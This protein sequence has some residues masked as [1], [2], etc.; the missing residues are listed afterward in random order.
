MSEF[1]FNLNGLNISEAGG[2]PKIP[3]GLSSLG[4][5]LYSS[6]KDSDLT[7]TGSDYI[8]W[9]RTNSERLR[10]GLPSLADIGYPRPPEDATLSTSTSAAA[11]AAGAETFKIK[12]PPGMTLEQA[13]AIFEQQVKTGGV[14]GFAP[15]DT[16]SAATQAFD[17]L[18]AAKAQFGQS[19]SGLNGNLPIGTNLQT[20]SKSLGPGGV[21][22]ANQIGAFATGAAAAI[23]S[24]RVNATGF[25]S[26]S[27]AQAGLSQ[28]IGMLPQVPGEINAALTRD[29]AAIAGDLKSFAGE[30]NGVVG[31][32]VST[33]SNVLKGT[34][35][36]GIGVADLSKAVTAL[37][38]LPGLDQNQV[39]AS[40]AQAQKLAS[41]KFDQ[42][43]NGTGVGAF[44]FDASQLEKA[45]LVK[46]GT[47]AEFLAQGKN[48]L[49]DVLKSPT[50]WTGKEGVKKVQDFLGNPALQ[51][52]IQQGLMK[53][54]L[55]ELKQLGVPTDKMTPQALS[56]LATN[57]AKSVQDTFKW[58]QNSPDLP[59]S[60]KEKFDKTA[61]NSAFAINLVENKVE[62]P[63]LKEKVIE[64]SENTVNSATVDAAASRVV[65]ND[66]VPDV[67]AGT[68]K[69]SAY[70]TVLTFQNFIKERIAQFKALKQKIEY[71]SSQY[72][73][74]TQEQWNVINS[75][76]VAIRATVRARAGELL[77]AA[78]A[79]T[80]S[81]PASGQTYSDKNTLRQLN[82]TIDELV[83][84]MDALNDEI[85]QLVKNLAGKIYAQA[86]RV[87]NQ[88][89]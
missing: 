21:D 45:G 14:T 18:E 28:A 2:F 7:Y 43:T 57:A 66:K 34:P 54:G 4:T 33:I 10:R 52:K 89:S 35:T 88:G 73:A 74:I 47:A 81:I 70:L 72:Q 80:E 60:V 13:R 56:G 26:S 65:G 53:D 58:T 68:S 48:E 55:G 67:V 83:V 11:P 50:V 31:S 25:V 19:L 8:V 32:A 27:E 12:G 69:D 71:T 41:Q 29:G 20:L 87:Q 37:G 84:E 44:G 5:S 77:T 75:E 16:L 15:G 62:E 22:A 9:D 40:I 63:V 61:V 6:T 17:G 51:T 23:N 36:D 85:R 49:L 59:A 30:L 46:P 1:T 42:M 78:T 76:A 3:A 64:P 38:P 82:Y 86:I 24:M 79:A 39:T